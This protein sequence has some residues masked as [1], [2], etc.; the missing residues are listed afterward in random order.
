MLVDLGAL[1]ICF[2]GVTVF[3]TGSI[4]K[5]VFIKTVSE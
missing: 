3:T 2:T 5:A 1:S 4:D